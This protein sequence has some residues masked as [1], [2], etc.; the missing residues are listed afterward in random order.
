M[1]ASSVGSAHT[2]DRHG[3]RF[4]L[5]GKV[6][7]AEAIA[8]GKRKGSIFIIKA[9]VT[10]VV[11]QRPQ[12]DVGAASTTPP[13]P[14]SI[15][16]KPG[17][18]LGYSAISAFHAAAGVAARDR[19]NSAFDISADAEAAIAAMKAGSSGG[20]GVARGASTK[21]RAMGGTGGGASLLEISREV[22]QL[23]SF[24]SAL[25]RESD[26]GFL[27]KV[28]HAMD[29]FRQFGLEEIDRFLDRGTPERFAAGSDVVL[30]GATGSS[31]LYLVVE[32]TAC[33]WRN[34]SA[35][36]SFK[37]KSTAVGSLA[38]RLSGRFGKGSETWQGTETWQERLARNEKLGY[39]TVSDHFGAAGILS[40]SAPRKVT[41]TAV[42][43]LL[44]LK[45][46]ED[47]F[48]DHLEKVK[49]GL[50]RELAHRQW[51]LQNRGAVAWADL[52]MGETLGRGTFGKVKIVHHNKSERNYALKSM[53]K[54][55]WA[56]PPAP[57]S[58]PPYSPAPHNNPVSPAPVLTRNLS[59][60]LC[61]DFGGSGRCC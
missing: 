13:P 43:E 38:S 37:G 57:P 47:A 23:E 42:T 48:G 50:A 54:K 17:D 45:L 51:V 22:Q 3:A 2:A 55:V 14:V 15:L 32:G 5:P 41:T 16:F 52:E 28:V 24:P 31:P 9:G 34:A 49:H 35:S 33:A 44:C 30:E 12:L 56:R 36:G 21:T 19:S 60:L 27:R 11:L 46:D 7:V 53:R 8:F 4:S 10:K 1:H 26:R 39:F 18:V 6:H 29:A 58:P 59:P 61:C 20:A 25:L 40:P